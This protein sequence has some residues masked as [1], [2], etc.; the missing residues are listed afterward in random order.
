MD[1]NALLDRI[2]ELVGDRR[3]R[4]KVHAVRHMIE[5]GFSEKNMVNAIL[6]NSKIIELYDEDKRCLILGQFLW[7]GLVRS[8]LHI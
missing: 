1:V 6:G 7:N 3:Y 4:V 2:K 8:W 5:E